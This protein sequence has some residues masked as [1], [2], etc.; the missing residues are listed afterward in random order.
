[1]QKCF[2][3]LNRNDKDHV[4][5]NPAYG[6]P[7]QKRRY[8]VPHPQIDGYA[9]QIIGLQHQ[10]YLR[11]FQTGLKIKLS[12]FNINNKSMLLNGSHLSY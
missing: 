2:I 12:F 9:E 5:I 6:R 4:V 10:K 1:M 7:G 11:G 8:L 3:L